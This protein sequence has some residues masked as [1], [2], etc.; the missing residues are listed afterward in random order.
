M[1]T[2]TDTHTTPTRRSAISFSAAALLAG[3]TVPTLVVTAANPDAELIARVDQ[4]HREWAVTEDI[5]NIVTEEGIT[6]ESRAKDTLM[7]PALDDWN[8]STEI[9]FDM[10]PRTLAGLAAKAR[11]VQHYIECMVF[12]RIDQTREEQF[13]DAEFE[14]QFALSLTNDLIRVGAA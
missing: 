7:V 10:K 14:I 5:A 9:I 12:N 11:A 13:A 6:P 2:A 4:M 8:A 3:L 1:Q